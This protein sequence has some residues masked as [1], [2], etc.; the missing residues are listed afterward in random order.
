MLYQNFLNARNQHQ[1]SFPRK[2]C[3]RKIM[4]PHLDIPPHWSTSESITLA[5]AEPET[6]EHEAQKQQCQAYGIL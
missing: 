6:R 1:D 5:V 4:K 3:I 2:K